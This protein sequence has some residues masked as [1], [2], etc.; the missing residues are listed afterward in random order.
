MKF[1]LSAA[2]TCIATVVLAA[3][4][5]ADNS[6]PP[7]QKSAAEFSSLDRNGDK[8]LSRSEAGYDDRLA[9][10]FASADTNGDGFV[11]PEEFSARQT[12]TSSLN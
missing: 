4:A 8:R 9:A 7:L 5:L 3:S 6:V 12:L 1:L 10:I 11:S 2:S